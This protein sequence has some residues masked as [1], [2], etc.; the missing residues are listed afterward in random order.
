MIAVR[1]DGYIGFQGQAVEIGQLAVL[2]WRWNRVT[3][4]VPVQDLR[5]YPQDRSRESNK[6]THMELPAKRR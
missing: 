4:D 6:R 1:P 3:N 5:P 2:A